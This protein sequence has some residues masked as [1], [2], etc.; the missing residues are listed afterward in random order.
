MQLH[1]IAVTYTD[2]SV[3][4]LKTEKSQAQ[5]RNNTPN[6]QETGTELNFPYTLQSS[7]STWDRQTQDK[8]FT[9]IEM[10]KEAITIVVKHCTTW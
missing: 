3:H 1:W 7:E 4:K 2:H 9:N 10:E 6:N 8:L 5:I